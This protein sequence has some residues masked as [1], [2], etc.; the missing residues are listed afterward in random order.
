MLSPI[1]QPSARVV[2]EL[3]EFPLQRR[4]LVAPFFEPSVLF[5]PASFRLFCGS[6]L[7]QRKQEFSDEVPIN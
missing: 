3:Q 6:G 1:R 7:Q 2:Q 4:I 5:F